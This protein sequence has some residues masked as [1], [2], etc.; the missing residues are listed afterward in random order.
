M[1]TELVHTRADLAAARKILPGRVAVVMTMGALHAGH[2]ELMR[3]A[4]A[5]ADHVIVTIFVNPLQFGPNED[6]DKYPRTLESDLERAASKASTW[7]SR[8]AATRCIRTARR[9]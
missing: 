9:P 4:R 3:V 8:R 7:S 1:I 5:N 2:R 6:F